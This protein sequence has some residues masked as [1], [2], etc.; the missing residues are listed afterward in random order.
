VKEVRALLES[1]QFSDT[2]YRISDYLLNYP[3]D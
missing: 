1:L 2:R 3:V